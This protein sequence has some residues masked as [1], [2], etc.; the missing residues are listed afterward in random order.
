MRSRGR[1]RL[2]AALLGVVLLGLAGC[3]DPEAPAYVEVQD[4]KLTVERPAAWETPIEVDEPWSAG[5][6]LAPDSIEQIQL[7]GDFGEYATAGEAV[8]TLIGQAQI[9]LAEFT[10]VETRDVEVEGATT[11][12]IVRYTFLDNANSQLSGEWIVAAHWPYPQSVAVSILTPRHD[13]DVEQQVLDSMRMR[14]VL[15]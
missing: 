10:V 9:E 3:T 15:G 14:P 8:G 2:I 1:R 4:G 7:S 13:P 5:F 6:R 11:A 12:Q